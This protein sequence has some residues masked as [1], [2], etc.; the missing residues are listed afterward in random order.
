MSISQ[1]MLAKFSVF[2]LVII[3]MVAALGIATKPVVMPLA[4]IVT[5]P[6]FVPSGVVAGG[7]YMMW[8][9]L[10][11]GLTGKRGAATLIGIIQALLVMATG[12][13]GSHGAMSLVTY[14]IPGLLADLG[15]LVIRHQ[16]CCNPCAFLAGMLANIGGS[17]MVNLVYFR[18]P[19]VPLVLSLSVAALSGGLGGILARQILKQLARIQAPLQQVQVPEVSPA[20]YHPVDSEQDERGP[21]GNRG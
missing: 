8:L 9:V 1:K 21:T 11:A 13:S 18:L 7:I 12:I 14:T 20:L 15:L 6:L 5:G 10:G 3:A 2:D 19:L 4:R 17:M 16:V